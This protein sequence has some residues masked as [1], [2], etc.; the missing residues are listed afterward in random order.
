MLGISLIAGTYI[1]V[2]MPA[3]SF[4]DRASMFGDQAGLDSPLFNPT[5][6][7]SSDKTN[8]YYRSC[9]V[10]ITRLNDIAVKK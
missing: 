1:Y 3:S 4:G 10:S 9:Q 6:P 7:Y 2:T 5:P 8:P